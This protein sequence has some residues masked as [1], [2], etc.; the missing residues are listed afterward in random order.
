MG[1]SSDAWH[2]ACP[3]FPSCTFLILPCWPWP[4]LPLPSAGSCLFTTGRATASCHASSPSEC[5]LLLHC[6][7]PAATC[8]A[9]NLSAVHQGA[10]INHCPIIAPT[11]L[12]QVPA[13]GGA[14]RIACT[15]CLYPCRHTWCCVKVHKRH[16]MVM[17]AAGLLP[18]CQ[19]DGAL[20]GG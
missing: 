10:S 15:S 12:L 19:A 17:L 18:P 14:P 4:S 9:A 3:R 20:Q 1:I 16:V 13:A 11:S 5:L 2:A 8:C 6:V 7:L